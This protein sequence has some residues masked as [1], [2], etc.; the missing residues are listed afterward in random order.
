MPKPI[1]FTKMFGPNEDHKVVKH[2]N[3]WPSDKNFGDMES[4]DGLRLAK[5]DWIQQSFICS[6]RFHLSNGD[7]SEVG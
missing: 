3:E 1:S 6:M 5:I 7:Y 4:H 2:I